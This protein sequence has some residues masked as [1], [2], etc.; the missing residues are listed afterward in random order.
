LDGLLLLHI[1]NPLL[2][3]LTYGARLSHGLSTNCKLHIIRAGGG[4]KIFEP[5]LS[6]TDCRQDFDPEEH[7]CFVASSPT[8]GSRANDE[9]TNVFGRKAKAKRKTQ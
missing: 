2:F 5:C 6:E 4:L 1:D 8:T 9:R 7:I 3:A